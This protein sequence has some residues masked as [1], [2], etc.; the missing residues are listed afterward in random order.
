[1]NQINKLDKEQLEQA[2]KYKYLGSVISH[3]RR[4]ADEITESEGTDESF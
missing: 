4:L 2:K 1:M 3:N